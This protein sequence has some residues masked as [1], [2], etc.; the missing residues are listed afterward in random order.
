MYRLKISGGRGE[1]DICDLLQMPDKKLP[2]LNVGAHRFSEDWLSRNEFIN[3]IDK[4]QIPHR[5]SI[6]E[7]TL[8]ETYP[9]PRLWGSRELHENFHHIS[10]QDKQKC[11]PPFYQSE[12]E[13]SL[14]FSVLSYQLVKDRT[15][16]SD[17]D[18]NGDSFK[19]A[20]QPQNF[21]FGWVGRRGVYQKFEFTLTGQDTFSSSDP[22]LTLSE[23]PSTF[24]SSESG[25]LYWPHNFHYWNVP[26]ITWGSDRLLDEMANT[27]QHKGLRKLSLILRL[28]ISN[29]SPLF[30]A[31]TDFHIQPGPPIVKCIPE[32]YK[33][34]ITGNTVETNHSRIA[35]IISLKMQSTSLGIIGN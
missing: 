11:V 23:E 28:K 24:V 27:L 4:N 2:Q 19:F 12:Q 34:A 21:L 1:I 31:P 6:E 5:V 20:V 15:G 33:D 7:N 29:A 9:K 25:S 16:S 10:L 32:S 17:N 26:S 8:T 18:R 13:L 35:S 3:T 14:H 30:H 22:L